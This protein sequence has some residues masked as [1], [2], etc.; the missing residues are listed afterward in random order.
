MSAWC[1]RCF[2]AFVQ[3]FKSILMCH[4]VILECILEKCLEKNCHLKKAHW[5]TIKVNKRQDC[6]KAEE[7]NQ[8][9]VFVCVVRY[10]TFVVVFLA[11]KKCSQE[12]TKTKKNI[13]YALKKILYLLWH[14]NQLYYWPVVPHAD[15]DWT[16][17]GI[18]VQLEAWK[19]AFFQWSW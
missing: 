6:G 18:Q 11:H 10:L 4:R 8:D 12:F 15:G 13:W 14:L 19:D 1:E 3:S 16:V 9:I 5:Q 7:E 17:L 2:L